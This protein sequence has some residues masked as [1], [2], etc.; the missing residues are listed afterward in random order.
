MRQ[1]DVVGEGQESLLRAV[2]QVSFGP[3]SFGVAGLDDP[4]PRGPDFAEL[5]EYL[6]LETL[7]FQAES[8]RG[9]EFPLRNR[10]CIARLSRPERRAPSPRAR[11]S[12]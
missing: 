4:R 3:A 10:R 12:R 8:D 1:P 9:A 5:E 6:R 7:I 11:F 2:V